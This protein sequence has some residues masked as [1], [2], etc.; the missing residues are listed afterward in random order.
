MKHPLGAD[1][2]LIF[3]Y[4]QICSIFKKICMGNKEER[5]SFFL[6]YLKFIFVSLRL[7]DEY[8]LYIVIRHFQYD[9][10][11]SIRDHDNFFTLQSLSN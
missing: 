10:L 5:I 9:F 11:N 2:I 4:I 7:K 8:L 6:Q 1:F 3:N